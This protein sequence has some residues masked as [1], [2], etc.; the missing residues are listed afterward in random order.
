MIATEVVEDGTIAIPMGASQAAGT[1]NGCSELLATHLFTVFMKKRL[2]MRKGRVIPMA[3][4]AVT[5][6]AAHLARPGL[7]CK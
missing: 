4:P 6:T 7:I 5:T 2:L 1:Y 3:V